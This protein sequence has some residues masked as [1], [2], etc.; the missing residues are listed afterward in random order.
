MGGDCIADR[1]LTPAQSVG[2]RR[3]RA[4]SP[5]ALR[6]RYNTGMTAPEKTP[7]QLLLTP[8]QFLKGVG[9]QR[10]ELLA[11]L[12]LHTARDVL[13][14]FPRDY[15]DLTDLRP[16]AELAEDKL[17]SVCGT[18]E[19]ADLRATHHGR[20]HR[21]RAPAQSGG[22]YLRGVWF[23][24]PFVRDRFRPGQRVMFS[25]K[26]KLNGL[27]WETDAPARVTYLEARGRRGAAGG[28]ILPVYPLTEG[29]QQYQMRRIVELTLEGYAAMLDEVFPAEYLL[30][31]DLAPAVRGAAADPLPG[32]PGDAGSGPAGDW[33]TRSCSSCSWPWPCVGSSRPR[34]RRRPWRGHGEDRRADSPAVPLRADRRA[35]GGDRADRRRH[36]PHRA[37]EP[38]LAG[39]RG[40][41]QDGGGRG[42]RCC[43]PSPMG[44]RPC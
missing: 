1:T 11:R 42:T 20:R 19:E 24:Q 16:I 12:G 30:A 21:R 44:S 14:C 25:G 39:R 37:D 41:R 5:A 43:W 40:Q 13:F 33:S 4:P 15:Q 3:E 18:V 35:A 34:T 27:M 8:V 9:P 7:A 2:T 31:H 10:A 36:G 17:Q 22:D 29:L 23:N 6:F 38:A 26:P 32:R 28:R